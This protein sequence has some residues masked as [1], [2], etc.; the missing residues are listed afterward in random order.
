MH[1]ATP[2]HHVL[3]GVVR[4]V[5]PMHRAAGHRAPRLKYR[6]MHSIAVHPL[7]AKVWQQCRVNVQC[8]TVPRVHAESAQVPSKAY[9]VHIVR[10]QCGVHSIIKRLGGFRLHHCYRNAVRL[11]SRHS[12]GIRTRDDTYSNHRW[13]LAAR[14]RMR[15]IDNGAPAPR[16]ERTDSNS[17][18]RRQL[19]A[20]V[21]HIR[22]DH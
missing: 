8:A 22:N 14:A 4:A 17:F 12:A 20:P 1:R 7:A 10:K 3:A 2:L 9:K 21:C 16:G 5:H 18:G 6:A 15:N 11:A 13:N 19:H